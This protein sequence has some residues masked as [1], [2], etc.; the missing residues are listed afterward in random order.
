MYKA[1]SIQLCVFDPDRITELLPMQSGMSLA[2]EAEVTHV[3]PYPSPEDASHVRAAWHSV[4]VLTC[5]DHGG[6]R[7]SDRQTPAN[8]NNGAWYVGGEGGGG[9]GGG[10][11]AS[12]SAEYVAESAP[13]NRRSPTMYRVESLGSLTRAGAVLVS[14]PN[15]MLAVPPAP[16]ESSNVAA[17]GGVQLYSSHR[18]LSRVAK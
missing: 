12:Q 6:H 16:G 7:C 13:V 5:V 14:A 2:H 4:S 17:V 3:P 10:D 1:G 18:P 8:Q 9:E 15:T 11:T